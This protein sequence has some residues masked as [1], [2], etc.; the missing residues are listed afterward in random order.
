MNQ[1]L[2]SEDLHG[3]M[4]E[5]SKFSERTLSSVFERPEHLASKECLKNLMQD[6]TTNGLLNSV[7]ETGI[8]LW[9][10]THDPLIL[11]FSCEALHVLASHNAGLAYLFHHQSLSYFLFK[12]LGFT[13]KSEDIPVIS[14]QGHFG[15]ARHSLARFLVGNASKE[16]CEILLDYFHPEHDQ[17]FVIHS[18]HDW[19][20][21]LMPSFEIKQD[22]QGQ[23]NGVIHFCV[24]SRKDLDVEVLEHGHGLNEVSVF[25]CKKIN[26]LPVRSPVVLSEEKRRELYA[27]A[28]Q[29]Q[30]MGLV[31]IANGLIE[32][33]LMQ[34]K[35]YA[36]MRVQGGKTI[37][38]HPA[39]Q[40]MLSQVKSVVTCG[41]SLINSLCRQPL[42]L[43]TL[44]NVA[45]IRA[46]LH[47]QY[48][49]ASNNAMQV[50]GGMG[51]MKDVGMEKIV[52][53]NNQLKLMNGT[54]T[55][56]M[57]FIAELECAK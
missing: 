35:E 25:R 14:L 24:W 11:Q 13:F 55:E 52:R 33:A 39:I 26:T 32:K 38:H 47:P 1:T 37:E 46:Q 7:E 45:E 43:S 36:A 18:R 49:K 30:W 5:V 22:K 6:A 41:Q 51:Y 23:S 34:A 50:F 40:Q 42:S 56:L 4:N 44:S 16:D 27:A 20:H 9:E 29:M 10:N 8:S 31:S 3:L 53:D 15:L 2:V 21:L 19:S 57:L 12:Q 28:L 17:P 48:C 54:P